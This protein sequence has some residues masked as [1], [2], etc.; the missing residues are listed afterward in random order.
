MEIPASG[1]AIMGPDDIG[2]LREALGTAGYTSTGIAERI[3]PAAVRGGR[4]IEGLGRCLP[5][6]LRGQDLSLQER[7]E[8]RV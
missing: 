7:G 3:G 5:A 6:L 2:R 4:A 1:P 8:R